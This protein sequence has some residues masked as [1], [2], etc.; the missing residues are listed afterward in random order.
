MRSSN[1]D[2]TFLK[3]FPSAPTWALLAGASFWGVVWYPYRLLA[4]AGLDGVWSTILT[5][6]FALAVGVLVFPRAVASLRRVTPLALL[7]GLAIGWSKLG[8]V[9]AVLGGEVMRVLLL[10]YLAPLWTVP[11]ARLILGECLDRAGFGVMALA[12]AGAMTM[13]WKP[14]LGFP[15]PSAPAE[16]LRLAPGLPVAL[17]NVPV[18]RVNEPSDAAEPIVILAGG[19]F[20]GLVHLA[21]SRLGAGEA[22]GAAARCAGLIAGSGGTRLGMSLALQYGLA[23]MSAH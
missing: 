11:L 8:Y 6:G 5:Y 21:Q 2:T 14:E 7:M 13:L 19:G 4:R 22:L 20:A 15:W 10:F 12:L 23:R 3:S 17:R 1:E 9:L 16:W 18:R